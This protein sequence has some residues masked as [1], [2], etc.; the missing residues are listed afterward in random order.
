MF[1]RLVCIARGAVFGVA[2]F[3]LASLVSCSDDGGYDS[4]ISVPYESP[5]IASKAN[6]DGFVKIHAD[7]SRVVMGTN[8]ASA[9]SK[10]RSQVKVSFDYDFSIGKHEV[11]CSEFNYVAK[12]GGLKLRLDCPNDL[13]PASGMTFYD[14]VLFANAKSKLMKRDTAYRYDSAEFD[15]VGRCIDLGGYSFDEKSDGFRLP[16]EAE[17][18]LVAN[19]GWN[20][21]F[22]WTAKNSGLKKREVCSMPPNAAG[23]CDMVGNVMEWVNDW[24]G[25][26]KDTSLVDFA[27][28]PDGGYTGERVVKG[29]S[30]RNSPSAVNIYNRMDIYTVISSTHAEYVG[31]RLAYGE[32]PNAT[33]MNSVGKV[34]SKQVGVHI[35]AKG[36]KSL[37]GTMKT[38]LVFRN[39]DA[40]TLAYVDFSSPNLVVKDIETPVDAYHPDISPN[41]KW[42]A[43]S[44]GMEGVKGK[45]E[46]YVQSLDSRDTTFLKLDVESAAIPRWRIMK[47]GDTVLVFVTDAGDNSDDDV[48][49]NAATW[50]VPFRKGKFGYPVKLLDGAYHGGIDAQN[51]MAVT[52]A[53][54]LR[55]RVAP[56][57]SRN[58]MMD[59]RDTLWYGG[60]QAC[61]VSLA[62]DGSK[63]VAFL[64]FG[65]ETGHKFVGKKYGVHERILIADST[66]KL[67]HSVKAP[68]GYTFDHV[69]WAI[70]SSSGDLLVATLADSHGNHK[71]IVAVNLE[72]DSVTEL[73]G[74]E[75]LWHP[76]L[77]SKDVPKDYEDE[78]LD[79]DSAGVYL[80]PGYEPQDL[81]FRVK[82]EV[83]WKRLPYTRVIFVG[84]S[85]MEFGVDPDMY[86]EL[87]MTNVGAMGIDIERD[88]S[89]ITNYVFNHLGKVQV[90]A[91]SLDLDGFQGYLAFCERAFLSYPGYVY[92]AN[93]DYW[94]EGLPSGFIDAVE[95]YPNPLKGSSDYSNRGTWLKEVDGSWDDGGGAEIL[96]DTVYTK[97]TMKR[98]DAILKYYERLADFCAERKI[99]FVG[100][101]FPQSPKYR[102]TGSLGVY[103]IKRSLTEEIIKKLR[104]WEKNNP[105]FH[106]M[107]ENK[108]G[109]HDYTDAMAQNRDHLNH[110]G[111]KQ[112]TERFV[113]FMK[114]F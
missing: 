10:E 76:C 30:Y 74:G 89:F 42:I 13:Y 17:W 40:G 112:L 25:A 63:R 101:I 16:T 1:F 55:A 53:R 59:G 8:S 46:V 107:D 62:K 111:A 48:F 41:G 93:H 71:Q 91:V 80:M 102:F 47:T 26:F 99:H 12:K 37:S 84:S 64:D 98:V 4:S 34:S 88:V 44:T 15:K 9:M 6:V 50:Q 24:L 73:I 39:E 94:R 14:A 58:V 85:R 108:M 103:G 78:A 95:A 90:I 22:S 110:R 43:Y 86:P 27:G 23:V 83:F 68:S 77:W 67:V 18:T 75:D 2:F 114:T 33:W 29:G 81:V 32:I 21:D 3:L 5:V 56:P 61:N 38:I 57:K 36:V 106:L 82:M 92:D 113:E 52:G 51:R 60:E 87:E 66:G 100:I 19:Q 35:S 105:Y 45:S 97:E 20:I 65:G 72:D 28:A 69:E 31:F 96:Y 109:Y 11:T 79:L 70:H 7:G 104:K 54:L 49:K